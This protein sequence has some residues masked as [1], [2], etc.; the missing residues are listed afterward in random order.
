MILAVN[1]GPMNVELVCCVCFFLREGVIHLHDWGISSTFD[2]RFAD[3]VVKASF[4]YVFGADIELGESGASSSVVDG[5]FDG[6]FEGCHIASGCG[7]CGCGGCGCHS[8]F[9]FA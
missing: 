7:C 8:C 5:T 1:F 6:G 2:T 9:L 3:V 4:S